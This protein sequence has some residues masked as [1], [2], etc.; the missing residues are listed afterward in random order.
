MFYIYGF[1][2][3]ESFLG[4]DNFKYSDEDNTSIVFENAIKVDYIIVVRCDNTYKMVNN[5]N[6]QNQYNNCI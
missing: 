1:L 5:W 2:I 6:L 4:L 3:L